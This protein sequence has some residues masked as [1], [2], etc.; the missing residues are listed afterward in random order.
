MALAILTALAIPDTQIRTIR[1]QSFAEYMDHLDLYAAAIGITS[2]ILF[3]FAWN[4]APVVGWDSP[5]VLVCLVLAIILFPVFLYFELKLS[6]YPLIPWSVFNRDN[7][8]VLACIA[9]GWATFGIW[10][11]SPDS[12]MYESILM[13]FRVYYVWQIFLGSRGISPILGAAYLTPMMISGIVAAGTT[14][15]LLGAVRPAWLM[16]FSNSAFLTAAILTATLPPHQIYWAQ[17]FVCTLVA[18]F[19]MEMSFPAAT[20]YLSNS[21][22]KA[23]Q[24]VAASL[25]STV[26]NYSISL[27]LGF[28]G[29]VE[30]NVRH[31]DSPKDI[32]HGY[33]GALYIAV[34]FAGM[35]LATSVVFLAHTYWDDRRVQ[36]TDSKIEKSETAL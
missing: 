27:G 31:G 7:G 8:F 2:M 33:R 34:G 11:G 17:I 14:G 13:R 5:Y 1:L 12:L 22:E 16:V 26:V 4:Q 9:M 3:N 18:T 25:V 28:A 10:Y 29:T 24:G 6:K 35:A 20:V 36:G 19:G 15:F 23:H 30:V 21:I 32:L